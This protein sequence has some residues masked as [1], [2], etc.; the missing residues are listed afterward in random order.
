MEPTDSFK[1]IKSKKELNNNLKFISVIVIARAN[2]N[3]DLCVFFLCRVSE[4]M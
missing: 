2:E 3:A 1:S 4:S